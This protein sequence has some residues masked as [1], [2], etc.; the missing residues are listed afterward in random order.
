[1]ARIDLTS[2][3]REETMHNRRQLYA[4]LAIIVVGLLLLIGNFTDINLGAIC[5]PLAFIL[6]GVWLILRPSLVGPDVAQTQKIIGEV[7]RR[8]PWSVQ[9]EDFLGFV[10]EVDMDL[11]QAEIPMGQTR[12]RFYG[13]V[14]EVDLIVPADVGI[15]VRPIAFVS[16]VAMDGHK[17][18]YILSSP[19]VKSDHFDK[20]P[21]TLVVESFSFVTDIKVRRIDA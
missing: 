3:V 17:G 11:T 19:P 14:T 1:M 16:E 7:E 6:V 18:E 10:I 4:G 13:F 21:R 8:G 5:W 9:A 15:M 12:L 20:A 2:S